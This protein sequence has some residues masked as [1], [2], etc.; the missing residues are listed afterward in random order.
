MGNPFL[1]PSIAAVVIG[2]AR[3]TGGRGHYLGTLAGALFL[4]TLETLITVLSLSQGYRDLI[5]GAIIVSALLVQ[6]GRRRSAG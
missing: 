3:V 2:G 6:N 1:L 4:S 5:Q